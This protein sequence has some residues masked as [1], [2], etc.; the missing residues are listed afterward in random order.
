MSSGSKFQCLIRRVNV[1]RLGFQV[2]IRK[3]HIVS[4]KRCGLG[5]KDTKMAQVIPA[6]F[7]RFKSKIG[8]E[9]VDVDLRTA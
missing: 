5:E 7:C 2:F 6:F 3:N 1:S 9:D 4:R 8:A